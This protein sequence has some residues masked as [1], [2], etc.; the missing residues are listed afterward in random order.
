MKHKH[1][2]IIAID[3]F[4]ST[5]KST[6]AK[7]IA[8][9]LQL[10]YIDSGAMYRVVTLYALRNGMYI[11]QTDTLDEEKLRAALPY[12]DIDFSVDPVKSEQVVWM[13]GEIVEEEIRQ[14]KVSDSVSVISK[15][16]FVRDKLV[17][18]Q[19]AD[20]KSVV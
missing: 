12:V 9:N 19:R 20:R 14:M 3:G 15:L 18:K 11:P 1:H 4:T 8:S 13:N 16:K 17:E 6:L 10:K 7:D 5:G 2:L